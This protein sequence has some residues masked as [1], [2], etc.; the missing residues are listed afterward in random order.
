MAGIVLAT[1]QGNGTTTSVELVEQDRGRIP[2]RFSYG[3]FIFGTVDSA[4]V[5]LQASHDNTTFVDIAGA[6]FANTAWPTTTNLEFY[7]HF[8]RVVVANGL[9]SES[10]GVVL[11]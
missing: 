3:L 2:K 4:D 9:G 10:V 6:S 8:I 5:K 1:A 7:G 11:V